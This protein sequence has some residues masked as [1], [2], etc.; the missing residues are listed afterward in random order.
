MLQVI[1]PRRTPSRRRFVK[2]TRGTVAPE[3]SEDV[4]DPDAQDDRDRQPE[5]ERGAPEAERRTTARGEDEGPSAR[6]DDE[7]RGQEEHDRVRAF[8]LPRARSQGP[9]EAEEDRG[10]IEGEEDPGH[11][12]DCPF[13]FHVHLGSPAGMGTLS[14]PHQ[15]RRPALEPGPKP[16]CL[17]AMKR[18]GA[19][20]RDVVVPALLRIG[21]VLYLAPSVPRARRRSSTGP[22]APSIR[23]TID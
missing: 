9:E 18:T 3:G 22:L 16:A 7:C 13:Q 11:C 19:G 1:C 2:I 15:A 6:A 5:Y 20:G 23:A 12:L 8:A 4:A 14:S 17:A 21:Q 10:R